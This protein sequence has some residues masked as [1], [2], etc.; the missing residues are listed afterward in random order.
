MNEIKIKNDMKIKETKKSRNLLG[1]KNHTTSRDNKNHA[2]SWDKK[3]RNLLGQ[4]SIQI[5]H[6]APGHGYV[7]IKLK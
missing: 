4:F 6:E 7:F 5:Q 1:Q 3:S 2:T